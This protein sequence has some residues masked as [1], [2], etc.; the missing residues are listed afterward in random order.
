MIKNHDFEIFMDHESMLSLL[1]QYRKAKVKTTVY[2]LVDDTDTEI[3]SIPDVATLIRGEKAIPIT[4]LKLI[5][6][7]GKTKS[8]E[9]SIPSGMDLIKEPQDKDIIFI[10][11]VTE[12]PDLKWLTV[13][14]KRAYQYSTS[15]KQ[16][17]NYL[18]AEDNEHE[19]HHIADIN[20]NKLARQQIKLEFKD[21]KL[22]LPKSEYILNFYYRVKK[23]FD[24][25][26][27]WC[28]G[29]FTTYV[30]DKSCLNDINKH[31]SSINENYIKGDIVE[32]TGYHSVCEKPHNDLVFIVKI[33][34]DK[35]LVLDMDVYKEAHRYLDFEFFSM[36]PL[37]TSGIEY[38]IFH[39]YRGINGEYSDYYCSTKIE[40]KHYGI[41]KGP[42][43]ERNYS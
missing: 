6:V 20:L 17:I 26:E 13:R 38:T 33:N 1:E 3:A 14:D 35:D 34:I 11:E 8:S 21:G 37:L 39:L 32:I 19:N 42:V 10:H 15:S 7:F 9:I 12:D 25:K 2:G 22:I 5:K 23:D 41:L 24:N 40:D 36:V 30:L 29:D 43:K 18:F 31:Y 16:W 28:L 4:E 27:Y